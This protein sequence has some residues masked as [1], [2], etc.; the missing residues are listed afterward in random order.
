[1]GAER[2]HPGRGGDRQ[3]PSILM[4]K[5]NGTEGSRGDGL[6]QGPP[7]PKGAQ[8]HYANKFTIVGRNRRN[9]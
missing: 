3:N 5:K 8:W 4:Q 2:H 6:G 9:G 1:M 7:L